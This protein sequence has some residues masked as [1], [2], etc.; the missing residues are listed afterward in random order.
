MKIIVGVALIVFAFSWVS[1]VSANKKKNSSPE[2]IV[3][4]GEGNTVV[5]S[6]SVPL[7]IGA[8]QCKRFTDDNTCAPCLVSLEDQGCKI[9]D[10]IVTHKPRM[11][12][13]PGSTQSTYLLSCVGP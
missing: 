8:E 2:S 13:A 11:G 10:V 9:V 1:G 7:S 5:E 4:C 3:T 6:I 12:L